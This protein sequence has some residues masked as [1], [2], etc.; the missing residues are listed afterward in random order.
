MPSAESMALVLL[1]G[2]RG[3]RLQG[4][5]K[6]LLPLGGQALVLHQLAGFAAAMQQVVLVANRNPQRYRMLCSP[7]GG[8]VLADVLPGFQGPLVG[9]LT[10]MLNTRTTW[11]LM[12]PCDAPQLPLDLPLRLLAAGRAQRAQAIFAS[13]NGQAQPVCCLLHRS[14]ANVLE[15]AVSQGERAP[16]RWLA[17]VGAVRCE[18]A[19]NPAQCWSV[20]TPAELAAQTA[21][22]PVQK[23][24]QHA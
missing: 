9:M 6:G 22:W 17:T 14:L 24:A 23:G 19:A 10:G 13:F 2:G 3:S 21:R 8:V 15:A 20:N 1:A 16:A 5:D 18:F 4:Q 12:L 11:V 7:W